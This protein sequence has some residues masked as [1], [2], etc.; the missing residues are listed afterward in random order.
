[1]WQI[2]GLNNESDVEQKFLYGLLTEALPLGLELPSSVIQT[3]AN[4]RR[5]AIGKGTETKL[6]YPDYVIVMF[7]M[8]LVVIE[9]KA[10]TESVEEGYRQARLYAH[11]LN[12]L[13]VAGLNP[14]KF[15]V[16]SNGTELWYGHADQADPLSKA[17]V[18]DLGVYSKE[19]AALQELISWRKLSA[20]AQDISQAIRPD[21][22][23][24][25]RRLVGGTGLQNEEVGI[26]TFGATITAAIGA[27]F[28]P[29]TSEERSFIAQHGYRH[30]QETIPRMTLYRHVHLMKEAGISIADLHAGKVLPFRVRTIELGAP[31]RSWEDIRRAA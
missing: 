10:P 30:V 24:K 6:Y 19:L 15:I 9:A 21:S 4:L 25:P 29:T 17:L 23:F 2:D 8:P 18:A 3:K 11:E 13:F 26:N 14:T 20:Y 12:A 1:M 7:G 16:A 5:F 28:N 31:V 27:I 22:L